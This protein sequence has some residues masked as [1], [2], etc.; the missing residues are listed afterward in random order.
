MIMPACAGASGRRRLRCR[1]LRHSSKRACVTS[2]SD[3]SERRRCL[4][5]RTSTLYISPLRGILPPHETTFLRIC[6]T[7]P[8]IMAHCGVHAC[9][10]SAVRVERDRSLCSLCR[11]TNQKTRALWCQQ[12]TLT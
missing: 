2:S 11:Q 4:G 12:L 3:S 6:I 7:V 1:T 10:A 9:S 5:R 8:R